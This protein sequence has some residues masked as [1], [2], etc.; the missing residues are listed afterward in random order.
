MD[1]E[2]IRKW[3][4]ITN[5]YRN[6]QFWTSV[7]QHKHPELA[8]SEGKVFPVYDIYQDEAYNYIIFEIPGLNQTDLSLQLLSNTQLKISGNIQRVFP[9]KMEIKRE[10]RYGDFERVIKLPEP[11]EPQNMHTQIHNGGL[12]QIAYPRNIDP[13]YNPIPIQY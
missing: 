11:A 13:I 7:L 4:E 12:L 8:R 1:I 5:E 10:R 6:S 9:N 3:M 2:K